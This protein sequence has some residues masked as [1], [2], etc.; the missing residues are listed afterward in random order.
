MRKHRAKICL[1]RHPFLDTSSE[2]VGGTLGGM[3]TATGSAL[4]NPREGR[5]GVNVDISELMSNPMGQFTSLDT[6]TPE[7]GEIDPHSRAQPG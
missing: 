4:G 3:H 7:R 6:D 5:T 1:G 2:S